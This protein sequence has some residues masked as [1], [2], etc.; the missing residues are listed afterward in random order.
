MKKIKVHHPDLTPEEKEARLEN[1]KRAA[2]RFYQETARDEKEK[3]C[4]A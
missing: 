3:K 2:Q 1:I 4:T